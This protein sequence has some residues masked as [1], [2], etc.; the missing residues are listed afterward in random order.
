MLAVN[1]IRLPLPGNPRGYAAMLALFSTWL[2]LTGH[3]VF[4]VLGDSLVAPLVFLVCISLLFFLQLRG[5][6]MLSPSPSD[7]FV[8]SGLDLNRRKIVKQNETTCMPDD[9]LVPT[10]PFFCIRARSVVFHSSFEELS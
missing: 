9:V 5:Y 8:I 10:D 7:L 1:L 3:F 4:E 2:P 6:F